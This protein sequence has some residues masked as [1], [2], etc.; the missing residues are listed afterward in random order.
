MI[1]L[2]FLYVFVSKVIVILVFFLCVFYLYLCLYL[3]IYPSKHRTVCLPEN[4]YLCAPKFR[5]QRS[6]SGS[7]FP[8]C[9]LHREPQP[10]RDDVR[11]PIHPRKRAVTSVIA[12]LVRAGGFKG[13]LFG[14]EFVQDCLG[15]RW[16]LEVAGFWVGVGGSRRGRG[17][18]R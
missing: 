4:L 12:P 8:N 6:H 7:A 10:Q 3:L 2:M 14:R 17:R 13:S 15:R 16:V 18:G 5:L 11:E 1:V 9:I